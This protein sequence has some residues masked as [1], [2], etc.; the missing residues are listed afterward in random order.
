MVPSLQ[1]QTRGKQNT[2]KKKTSKTN[3]NRVRKR[4][5]ELYT[6]IFSLFET[7][8]ISMSPLI[9]DSYITLLQPY[10]YLAIVEAQ[11]G[12]SL[13]DQLSLIRQA[14]IGL[15]ICSVSAAS[16]SNCLQYLPNVS[17]LTWSLKSTPNRKLISNLF[18]SD[19][20]TP[21]TFA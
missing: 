11:V 8:Q 13:F 20:L 18:N 17:T 7:L 5:V 21:P 9:A 1:L 14:C 10:F 15:S 2:K 12:S 16:F 3:H 19:V 4:M 6:T